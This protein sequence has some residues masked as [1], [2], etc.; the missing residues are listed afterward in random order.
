[1]PAP[2]R[3]KLSPPPITDPPAGGAPS[4]PPFYVRGQGG[5]ALSEHAY[6]APDPCIGEP[7]KP[8]ET[9]IDCCSGHCIQMGE[10]KL[11]GEKGPCSEGGNACESDADCCEPGTPCLDGY[12]QQVFPQ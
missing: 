12:C 5:C 1:M 3:Q 8:C 11:C 7:N 2:T 10:V 4:T 9:G 6:F